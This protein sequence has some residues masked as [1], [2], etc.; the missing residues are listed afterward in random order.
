M[1]EESL[2]T[3]GAKR[4]RCNDSQRS[5]TVQEAKSLWRDRTSALRRVWKAGSN[6]EGKEARLR[7]REGDLSDRVETTNKAGP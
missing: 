6:A 3:V 7:D 2:S 5:L 1:A 4:Q